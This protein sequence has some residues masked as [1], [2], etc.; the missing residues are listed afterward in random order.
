VLEDANRVF[1]RMVDDL[2][3]LAPP[4]DDGRIVGLWIDDWRTYL[5]DRREFAERLRVDP[6]AR[7]L[8]TP[9]P[10]GR[11]ITERIDD[12]AA[13]NRIPACSTPLDA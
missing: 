5:G 3:D 12:F 8:V 7:L 11:H 1:A 13:D 9:A 2:A 10:G 6:D 4:G